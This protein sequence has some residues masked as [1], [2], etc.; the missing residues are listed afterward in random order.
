MP[1][2]AGLDDDGVAA[3][4]LEIEARLDRLVAEAEL[5]QRRLEQHALPLEEGE[6]LGHVLA[7]H[8]DGGV[9]GV[10]ALEAGEQAERVAIGRG[11][12]RLPRQRDRGQHRDALPRRRAP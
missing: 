2:E 4:Q 6:Q 11:V 3:D 1:L 10:A 12:E 5:H 9:P 7:A 8:V